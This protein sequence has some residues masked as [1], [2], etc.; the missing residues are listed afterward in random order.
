M[1][2]GEVV[3]PGRT[4]KKTAIGFECCDGSGFDNLP[5]LVLGEILVMESSS[6]VPNLVFFFSTLFYAH[7]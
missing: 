4:L 6:M 1:E 7:G 2:V 3:A 5:D